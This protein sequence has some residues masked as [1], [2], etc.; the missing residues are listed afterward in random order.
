MAAAC[1]RKYKTN[2][3]RDVKKSLESKIKARSSLVD[4]QEVAR[5]VNGRVGVLHS[6]NEI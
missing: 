6:E 1:A 2:A 5:S 4:E 3:M